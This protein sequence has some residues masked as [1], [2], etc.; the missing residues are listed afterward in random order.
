MAGAVLF[1]A[2]LIYS[3]DGTSSIAAL[4]KGSAPMSVTDEMGRFVM[5]N[6]EVREYALIYSS[7][8]TE[9]PLKD[10]NSSEDLVIVVV[11]DRITDL[12]EIYIDMP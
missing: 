8:T 10:P 12:G 4:D 9:F 11:A 3:A 5:S 2:P 1:L 7:G 6:V